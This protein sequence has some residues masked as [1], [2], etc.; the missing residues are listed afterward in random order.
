V[1]PERIIFVSR[2][3][4]VHIPVA[5]LVNK[6]SNL[7][8]KDSNL[9]NWVNKDSNLVN[10]V[11]KDSNLVNL[12]NKDSNLVNLVNKDSNLVNK[13][14]NLVNLFNKDSNLVNKDSNLVNLVNKDSNLVNK[15]SNVVNLVNKDSNVVNVVNKDSKFKS[16]MRCYGLSTVQQLTDASKNLSVFKFPVTSRSAWPWR[17]RHYGHPK[18][19]L[20][21]TNRQ[22]LT[23]GKMWKLPHAWFAINADTSFSITP[24]AHSDL[25]SLKQQSNVSKNKIK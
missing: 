3:I 1:I 14:S 25:H 18:L 6:D 10:L 9:V 11:N 2:G 19:R 13:D 5:L 23:A 8:N 7:V 22:G 16:C 17:W 15:D 21:F 24:S 12:V 4:T 20:P